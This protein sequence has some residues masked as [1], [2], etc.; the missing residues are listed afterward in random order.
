MSI[1]FSL[2]NF[3]IELSLC[4]PVVLALFLYLK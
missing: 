4:G 1:K 3:S 2:K